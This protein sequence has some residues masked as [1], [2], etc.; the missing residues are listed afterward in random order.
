MMGQGA[1]TSDE[2]TVRDVL[3][4][5]LEA[6]SYP[7]QSNIDWLV[8]DEMAAAALAQAEG[9]IGSPGDPPEFRA[10]LDALRNPDVR[11]DEREVIYDAMYDY[12]RASGTRVLSAEA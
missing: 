11:N 1:M 2:F 7:R 5:L 6:D 9:A 12:V 3:R 8:A 4:L 10:W